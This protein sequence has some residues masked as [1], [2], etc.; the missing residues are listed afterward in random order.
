MTQKKNNTPD[1]KALFKS[2]MNDLIRAKSKNNTAVDIL[3]NRMQDQDIA[4]VLEKVNNEIQQ[5]NENSNTQA[6]KMQYLAGKTTS[7]KSLPS[8]R[9]SIPN[10]VFSVNNTAKKYAY[11]IC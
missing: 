3:L 2:I 6:I 8:V 1:K 7:A 9:N 4:Y 5:L 10:L 11:I